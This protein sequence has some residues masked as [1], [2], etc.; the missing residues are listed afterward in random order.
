MLKLASIKANQEKFNADIGSSIDMKI[1]QYL[2]SLLYFQQ[3]L[4]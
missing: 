2:S 4:V 3:L 1:T